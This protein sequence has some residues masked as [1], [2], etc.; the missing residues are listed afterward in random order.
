MGSPVHQSFRSA[1][2]CPTDSAFT[3]CNWS[4]NADTY[5]DLEAI[6]LP[7]AC[8]AGQVKIGDALDP[9][10]LPQLGAGELGT[11]T[12][13]NACDGVV[14][15]A[16]QD[17][18]FPLCCSPQSKYNKKWPI[19]PKDLFSIYYDD[20]DSSDVLWT[21][22][23]EVTNNDKDDSSSS[24]EDGTDAYGFLM[25]DGPSGSIDNSFSTTNTIVRKSAAVP[26]VK[27]SIVTHNQTVMDAVFEHTEEVLHVYCNHPPGSAACAEIWIDGA[28]DTI[29]R[30]PDYV[31]EGPFARIVSM[32]PVA[33]DLP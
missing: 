3:D 27:R 4:N 11:Y 5:G 2:C 14:A 17:M 18:H 16:G 12:P 19:D 21:Y 32:T 9:E 15:P 10:P 1:L 23:D 29:I 33:Y 7:Q 26:N 6:C 22:S 28:E 8:A 24:E 31:G 20:P 30:M 25:L 13:E